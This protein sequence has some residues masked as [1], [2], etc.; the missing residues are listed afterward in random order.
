L[1][2]PCIDHGLLD[3][4]AQYDCAIL[5]EHTSLLWSE[6]RNLATGCP[7]YCR[8]VERCDDWL[9]LLPLPL[10]LLVL[11]CCCCCCCCC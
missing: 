11:H 2:A 9:L 8:A 1:L 7:S 10:L 5:F 6:H 3:K 4:S